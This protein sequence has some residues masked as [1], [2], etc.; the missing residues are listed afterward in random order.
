MKSNF[1]VSIMALLMLTLSLSGCF[2]DDDSGPGEY[3]GPIDLVVYYDATSGQIEQAWS[4]DQNTQNDG[5]TLTFDLL[6]Q[7]PVTLTSRNST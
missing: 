4:N 5:V 7:S 3:S 2:G 6:L 1:H